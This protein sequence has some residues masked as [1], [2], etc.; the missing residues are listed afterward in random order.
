MRDLSNPSLA[1]R[2][3][4]LVVL[5]MAAAVVVLLFRGTFS[6]LYGFWQRA[7]YSHGF[8][9]PL[10]S[11]YLLWRQR[12]RFAQ[13]SWRTSWS[14]VALALVG[15]ALYFLG[16]LGSITTLDAYALVIVIA[17]CVLGVMGWEAFKVAL[18]P[19]AL[20]FLMNPV[21]RFF[22][23]NLSLE[24]QLLSSQLG[25]ALMR[26]FGVSVFL[27]GNVIDLG[28]YKLQVAEACSG[29]NYLFPLMTLGVIIAYLFKGKTWMR[30]CLF[31]ST[32]PITAVMNSF[33]V[34]VIGI[35]VDRFGIEQAEGF[36][37]WFEG[38]V[39]FMICLLVLLAEAWAMLRLSGDRR[40]LRT[41]LTPELAPTLTAAPAARPREVGKPAVAVLLVLLA[42]VLPARALQ[43]RP[44][45]RP[46]R[47]SF[48]EFPLRVGEWHGR[49]TTLDVIYLDTLRLDD[50]VL[51]DFV[52][53]DAAGEPT[54]GIA[55]V[56]L[57]VAYYASQRGGQSAHSPRSCLPG[58]G[59]DIL[60]FGRREVPGAGS[61]GTALRVNRA[62]VEHGSERQLVYYWFQERG[63]NITSE[64][65]VKWYLFEDALLRNRSDGALVRLIT[66]LRQSEAP[67]AADAR[68]AQ[69]VTT[70]RPALANYL[71]N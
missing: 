4:Q 15:L 44:E 65:L 31:L 20:L 59:W 71:P 66:P 51:A 60:D 29:L 6:Y 56:N 21:P 54:G 11:A 61:N 23:N 34:G 43:Q 57:Y 19:I 68:L 25:V 67:A 58:G 53:S 7:E 13:L 17:G 42:A 37:H 33:R 30:W 18:A 39:I 47:E 50:Y 27:E 5:A 41:V 22:Y 45:L 24:L 38:W 35:L 28:N 46:K 32:I 8:V 3:P 52:R 48:A 12:A 1:L 63:R 55:P 10:I 49:R 2:A 9:I 40:S 36:L 69:F 70:V 62:L 26:L 64:Y 14:G 16:R